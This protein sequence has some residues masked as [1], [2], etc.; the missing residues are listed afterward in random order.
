LGITG[1]YRRFVKRYGSIVE[2][3]TQLLRKDCFIWGEEAQLAFDK[4]K[5]ALTTLSVL[6]VPNFDK[7]F[8][9]D[10]DASGKDWARC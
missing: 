1:Y 10:T 3:L 4:L 5:E 2:P 8:T 9:I 6:A 7:P